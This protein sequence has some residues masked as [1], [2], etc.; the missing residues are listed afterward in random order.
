MLIPHTHVVPLEGL[1]LPTAAGFCIILIFPLG[2]YAVAAIPRRELVPFLYSSRGLYNTW[3]YILWR[4]YFVGH[5]L[6]EVIG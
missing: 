3:Y 1:T 2:E 4:V 6:L 5:C